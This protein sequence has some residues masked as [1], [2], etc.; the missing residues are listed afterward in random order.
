[1]SDIL[2]LRTI[3]DYNQFHGLETQHPLVSL[4][5]FSKMEKC[6]HRRMRLGFYAILLKDEIY[7][8]LT[9]GRNKYDYEAGTL[10][11]IAPGQ[12]IGID[13]GG[14]TPHPQGYGLFFHPDLIRGTSLSHKMKNYTFFSYEVNEALHMSERERQTVF[15]CFGEIE[16]EL[17][18]GIDKH[19]RNIIVSNIEVLLN[20][21]LRFYDRQF[22]T[23]SVL[24]SDV[25]TRFHTLLN[26]YF[27]SGKPEE[28]G[29]PSVAWCA[30]QLHFSAN[31]FG[32]MVKKQ[33]G[34]SAIECIHQAVIDKVKDLLLETDK[35]ISEI[36]YETGF[37]YPQHLT[38]LFKSTAGCAPK[39]YREQA[40]TL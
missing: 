24:N 23:R 1:M 30:D 8:P 26:S 7:G 36:A 16:E 6:P 20:N 35:T 10:V 14:Y 33:T 29:L 17:R 31:Y 2:D 37:K 12:V 40:G 15:N 27:N 19:S 21:C 28:L 3:D 38:R 11:F 25:L 5:D 32:D 34:K 39:E 4:A 22:A 9:Y 18:H 13:D